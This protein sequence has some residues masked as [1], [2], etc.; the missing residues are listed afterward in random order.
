MVNIRCIAPLDEFK[1]EVWP[2]KCFEVPR[3]GD[4]VKSKSGRVL[5]I[6]SITHCYDVVQHE[7]YVCVILTK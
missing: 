4:Y 5:T 1:R 3:K 6:H 7:Y 2:D